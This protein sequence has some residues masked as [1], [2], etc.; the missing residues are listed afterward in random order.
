MLRRA[1]EL[2][3]DFIDTADSYGPFVAEELIRKAL[4]PYDGVTGHRHQGRPDCAPA[5]SVWP[6]LG[7]PE[8]LRQ[9]VEM[10]L[11]RLGVERIDLYQLHR[12]DPEVPLAEQFGVM[13]ELQ[14]EGKIRHLGLSEVAVDDDQGGPRGRSTSSACRTSTTS[15]T[16]SPRTCCEYCE[17][18]GHRLH[19]V[20][21]DRHRRARPAGRPA[22]RDRGGAPARRPRSSRWPGCCAARRWC[23][24]SRAPAR[25]PTSRRTP[26]PPTSSSPTS[27]SPTLDAIA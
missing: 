9:C 27:S 12:I 22:R 24:P 11:R 17:R 6:V 20:V 13:K 14:D 23:C 1:V 10:S 4:H 18:R 21:P 2:G 19:P 8:Y 7:R 26:P 5:P 16:G 25:S 15:A 3:V